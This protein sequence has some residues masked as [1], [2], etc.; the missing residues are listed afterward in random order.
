MDRS[1][2]YLGVCLEGRE[3]VLLFVDLGP[4]GQYLIDR[5]LLGDPLLEGE[6]PELGLFFLCEGDRS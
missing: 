6:L 3:D 2:T 5:S 1:R 4:L